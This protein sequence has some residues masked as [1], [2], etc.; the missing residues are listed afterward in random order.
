MCRAS[1]GQQEQVGG[2]SRAGAEGQV[3]P[4]ILSSTHAWRLG[5]RRLHDSARVDRGLWSAGVGA[6]WGRVEG[7]PWRAS[8]CQVFGRC[9]SCCSRKLIMLLQVQVVL[10]E[11]AEGMRWDG[12]S[13]M[14]ADDEEVWVSLL[15]CV[16]LL[17]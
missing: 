1:S 15:I 3:V 17:L 14:M 8:R 5:R 7:G 12:G 6:G 16:V 11:E 2:S 10:L 9:E 4:A 13:R